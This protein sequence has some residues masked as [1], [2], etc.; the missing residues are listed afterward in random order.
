[1]VGTSGTR[2]IATRYPVEEGLTARTQKQEGRVSNLIPEGLHGV[3][4]TVRADERVGL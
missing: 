1:M 3:T 4:T 2:E